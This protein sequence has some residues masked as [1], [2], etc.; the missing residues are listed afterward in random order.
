M[1]RHDKLHVDLCVFVKVLTAYV[2]I[3]TIIVIQYRGHLYF[4]QSMIRLYTAVYLVTILV[5]MQL[6]ICNYT[7]MLSWVVT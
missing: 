6:R 4:T 7:I 3:V 1:T 2:N 5:L